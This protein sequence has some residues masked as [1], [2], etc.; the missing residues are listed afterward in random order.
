MP[1]Q[2]ELQNSPKAINGERP[3][4][5][6]I[7]PTFFDY[8]KNIT[9]ELQKLGFDCV[10]MNTWLYK[11]PAYKILLRIAP[12]LVSK[13]STSRYIKKCEA[14]NLD[15]VSEVLVIKGEGLSIDFI[16]YLRRK[17]PAANL[18]LYLWDGVGNTRGAI[19]IAPAFDKVSTFDPEDAKQFTW[20]H[21]PLFARQTEHTKNPEET[22]AE[23]DWTFIGSLHSDRFSV[24]KRLTQSNS[25]HRFFAFGFVPGGLMWILRHLTNPRLWSHGAVKVSTKSIP[26]AQVNRIVQASRSV[27]DIEHPRQRGLT[28]RSIETLLLGRK[29]ITTNSEIRSSD[30]FHESRACVIDR[31]NPRIPH[32]FLTSPFLE[33]PQEIRSRYYIDNWLRE[34][35]APVEQVTGVYNPTSPTGKNECN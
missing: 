6:L 7:S 1:A 3:K 35:I 4:A 33:I 13:L 30:L 16:H 11:N 28:M 8:Y 21:R 9:E 2:S 10:W 32:E 19:T 31:R 15:N 14:L 22:Q 18:S 34:V 29:L 25:A 24:L 27:V 26:T 23:Y 12:G 17:F 5:F 20:H